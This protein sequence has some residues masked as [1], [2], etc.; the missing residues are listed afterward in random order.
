MREATG[1]DSLAI[2]DLEVGRWYSVRMEPDLGIDVEFIGI[3]G[4]YVFL[5][6]EGGLLAERWPRPLLEK[7]GITPI[8][9]PIEIIEPLHTTEDRLDARD[10]QPRGD[11]RWLLLLMLAGFALWL[12]VFLWT[13]WR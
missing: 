13:F 8:H 10:P 9:R 1:R 3:D 6:E 4:Q 5:R 12:C 2:D 7:C 11:K